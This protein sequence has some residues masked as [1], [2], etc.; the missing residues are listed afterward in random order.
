M[1]YHELKWQSWWKPVVERKPANSSWKCDII[2]SDRQRSKGPEKA[3]RGVVG[4]AGP[5]GERSTDIR[6]SDAIA[7]LRY[8]TEERRECDRAQ[9]T[10]GEMVAAYRQR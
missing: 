7:T 9:E 10:V 2:S 8:K 4:D 6:K 1:Q 3:P 5:E